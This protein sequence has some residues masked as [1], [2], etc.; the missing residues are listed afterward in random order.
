MDN[1]AT[2]SYSETEVLN[3]IDFAF[4]GFAVAPNEACQQLIVD[5]VKTQVVD[6]LHSN[7]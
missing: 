5:L 4:E 3:A 1:S 6:Y 7:M 2:N